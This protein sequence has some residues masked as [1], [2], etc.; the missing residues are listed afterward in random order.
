ME[1]NDN[2]LT[3]GEMDGNRLQLELQGNRYLLS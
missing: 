1:G 3:H 2:A